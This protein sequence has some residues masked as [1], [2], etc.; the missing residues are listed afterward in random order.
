MK[1]NL[2]VGTLVVVLVVVVSIMVY[3]PFGLRANESFKIWTNNKGMIINA[4]D[5]NASYTKAGTEGFQDAKAT[6]NTK[7]QRARKQGFQNPA[8][9]KAPTVAKPVAP[10][11]VVT[12]PPVQRVPAA[13]P[14]PMSNAVMAPMN[15][16]VAPPPNAAMMNT[17]NAP[18]MM[19][20]GSN[21]V[22]GFQNMNESETQGMNY[23][24]DMKE[25]FMTL[26]NYGDVAGGAKDKYEPI[27]AFDGVTLS[28]GNKVSSWRFTAPDEQLLGAE[29]T[30]GDDSLFIFKNNQCK[31]E[32]CGASF[33]CSGGCVCTSPEQRSYINGR[34]GN[35]TVPAED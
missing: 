1:T 6:L 20:V 14:M 31:P 16:A 3:H 33:S 28:T 27:G 29:F 24:K 15:N 32:C 21:A 2:L 18:N 5:A 23:R 12:P 9:P 35:R 11:P 8:P 7:L 19:N 17:S 34:G 26:Q 30:P 10:K 4:G 25:G 22:A 13:T